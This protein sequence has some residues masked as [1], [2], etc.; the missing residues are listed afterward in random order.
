MRWT[1]D[2]PRRPESL[3]SVKQTS[4]AP[5]LAGCARESDVITVHREFRFLPPCHRLDIFTANIVE[6][7]LITLG[8]EPLQIITESPVEISHAALVQMVVVIV[9]N[10]DSVYL[11]EQ[12]HCDGAR[13][14][15]LGT[16]LAIKTT[17]VTE[18]WVCED[19]DAVKL[20]QS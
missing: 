10:H 8:H 19:R 6:P 13:P 2:D 15:P 5:M 16:K 20:Y 17:S 7:A 9:A 12:I 14:I 18:Y 11:R 1:F 4:V 3:A